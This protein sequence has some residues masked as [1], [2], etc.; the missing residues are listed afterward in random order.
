M[1]SFVLVPQ[2]VLKVGFSNYLGHQQKD[3]HSKNAVS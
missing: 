3:C 1:T 2:V